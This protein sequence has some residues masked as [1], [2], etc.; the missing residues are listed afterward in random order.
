ML[1][2]EGRLGGDERSGLP[3]RKK[4]QGKLTLQH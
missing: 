3:K 2:G 1:P 4:W